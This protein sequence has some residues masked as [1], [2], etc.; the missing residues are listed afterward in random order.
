MSTAHV[1]NYLIQTMPKS[2][3]D[4]PHRKLER[5]NY[6]IGVVSDLYKKEYEWYLS[7][8]ADPV[9]AHVSALMAVC[10]K[11]PKMDMDNLAYVISVY[12]YGD[13]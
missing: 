8:T 12:Y 3:T 13:V 10:H 1:P 2:K 4:A 5:M 11:Y 7:A 6:A 9:Q